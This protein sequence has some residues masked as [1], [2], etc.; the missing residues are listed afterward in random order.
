MPSASGPVSRRSSTLTKC[1]S[2]SP[3]CDLDDEEIV[4]PLRPSEKPSSEP[5]W[6]HYSTSLIWFCKDQ[7]FLIGMIVLVIISSQAQVPASRQSKKETVVTYLCVSVIFI[8][9]GCTL[10]SKTLKE[11]YARW[12]IHLF[13]QIQ[14]F[15]MCSASIYGI[16]SACATN[17]SFMDP[18]M[19]VGMI[20]VACV[21]TTISSNVNMTKQAHGN[22][23]LTV[24]QSTLGNLIGP[25]ITP[26]LI[27][28]YT[29][30]GAWYT[31]ILPPPGALT[32]TY[33]RVFKQLGLSIYLPFV[34]PPYSPSLVSCLT[35]ISLY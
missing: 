4:T 33:R 20:F 19:L 26:L 9:T 31:D 29:G 12:K 25:F 21:P 35:R 32:A 18:A 15:L 11:N 3:F 28:M 17:P 23:A 8:I 22:H 6:R 2:D 5:A 13:V 24:V 14:C 34:S 1:Y 10:P 16:V 30:T 27:E 7:W